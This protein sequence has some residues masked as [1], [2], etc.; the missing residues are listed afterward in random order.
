[1][2]LATVLR[3]NNLGKN[4]PW[5]ERFYILNDYK[6]FAEKYKI[7]LNAIMTDYGYEEIC[8]RCAGL[9]ITGSA[10]NI[11]P[12]YYGGAPLEF[13][14]PVDEYALDAKLIDY[15]VKNGKPV[16]GICGGLQAINVFMGG[17]LKKVDFP[18]KHG[19]GTHEIEIVKD[20]FVW[21]VFKSERATVNTYHGWEIGKLAPGLDV[22][23][24]S[25]DGVIE[26]VEW[27]EKK[28]FATQWHPEQSF[29]TGDAIENKFIE[30]FI[31]CCK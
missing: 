7:G 1:M 17:T 24:K 20:S 11:D 19:S 25:A 28:I 6:I 15:F 27:K 2:N 18:E 3:Y 23:A 5:D 10:T 14:E 31:E 16:L 30:N 26:A 4:S 12:S 29:H 8:E 9:I 22:V 13:P 21:D